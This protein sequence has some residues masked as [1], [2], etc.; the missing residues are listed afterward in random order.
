MSQTASHPAD[1]SAAE[2]AL[3]Y[4]ARSLS[5]AEALRAILQRIEATQP[6]YNA[7]RL[8][9]TEGAFAQATASQERWQRGTPLGP[10]D[11][12]PVAFKDLL[13]VKGLPTRKGSLATPDTP[14][15][16]D[17]PA[18]ARLREAGAVL[19][20]KTNTAEFGWKGA[21]DTALAGVTRNPWSTAHSPT[22]SSGGAAVAAALGLGP[23][24]VATD[25]G[26]SIRVPASVCGA[27]GF[28][29]SYGRVPGFPPAHNG[30]LF[31]I[32]P[33]TRT[34]EDA[35]LLLNVIGG[36]D[37]RDWSSLPQTGRDW[38]IGLL[39]G[40]RGLRIAWSP[41]LGYARLAPAIAAVL[42]EAVGVFE[43]LGATVEEV[44]PGFAD[45]R[46]IL[47]VLA[48]ER[49][50]RLKREIAPRRFHLVDEEIRAAVERASGYT[51][52]DYVEANEARQTLA[53]HLRRFH[54][55]YDLLLT[56][57]VGDPVPRLG[58]R[59]NAPWNAP[60]NL[61]QQPA[62]SIQAGFDEQGLPVGL[63]I[64]GPAHHDGRV[65]RAAR[66]FEATRSLRWPRPQGLRGGA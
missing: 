62:A 28:K 7:Y 34:V 24:H 27:F 8:L 58:E 61:T 6:V 9:D 10:L 20:G 42:Q 66:A 32:G 13:H 41:T 30:N 50:I 56:P 15:P 2:L 55:R 22:G 26:G 33:I 64:V 23:L 29:P 3:H 51:L 45:P 16:E 63:Q 35:A 19:L 18:A 17:S 38:R 11:G 57:V 48:A 12:V 5:P 59:A 4:R 1:L 60:F 21:T 37:A 14:Q 40:V 65:L 44:D 46:P 39:D 31:H 25:G 36:Y 43:T 52:S 47:D 54:E 49:A 53:I